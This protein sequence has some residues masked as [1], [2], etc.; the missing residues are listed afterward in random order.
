MRARKNFDLAV[1]AAIAGTGV[2]YLFEEWLQPH[3]ASGQLEPMLEPWW[4]DFSGSLLYY[5]GDRLVPA[6]LRAFI[7]FLLAQRT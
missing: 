1:E 7:D 3:L 2:I 6:P 4:Q 5:D